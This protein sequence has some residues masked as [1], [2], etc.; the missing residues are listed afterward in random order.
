MAVYSRK[1][2]LASEDCPHFRQ[3]EEPLQNVQTADG[4]FIGIT[5]FI[6][7]VTKAPSDM[8]A[9]LPLVMVCSAADIIRG[10]PKFTKGARSEECP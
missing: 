10:I 4:I 7:N 9:R 6:N 2:D 8:Q 1:S 3:A 5:E